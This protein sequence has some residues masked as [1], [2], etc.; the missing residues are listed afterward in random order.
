MVLWSKSNDPGPLSGVC[1]K[2]NNRREALASPYLFRMVSHLTCWQADR[3]DAHKAV[4]KGAALAT[5]VLGLAQASL[6]RFAGDQ[7]PCAGRMPWAWI[8]GRTHRHI[9][10]SSP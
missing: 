7:T 8:L 6:V 9:A 10:V 5:K 1:R 3:R 2:G 4:V